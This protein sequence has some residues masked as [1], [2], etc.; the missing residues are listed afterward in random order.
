MQ[1]THNVGVKAGSSG[2]SSNNSPTS[3]TKSSTD[4]MLTESSIHVP[5]VNGR[6]NGMQ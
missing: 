3:A 4:D 2:S 6:V 1:R 5:I